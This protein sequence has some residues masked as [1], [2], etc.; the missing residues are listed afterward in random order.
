MALVY[1]VST[2]LLR[3]VKSPVRRRHAIYIR[4]INYKG[5]I[6]ARCAHTHFDLDSQ[7]ADYENIETVDK[8]QVYQVYPDECRAIVNDPEGMR[9]DERSGEPRFKNGPAIPL[10]LVFRY[11]RHRT[12]AFGYVNTESLISKSF[13]NIHYSPIRLSNMPIF[14]FISA[15]SSLRRS[16]A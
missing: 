13:I 5:S 12:S 8:F 1:F 2:C 10:N 15:V 16:R 11:D 7:K 6:W 9:V 14:L 3:D 4:T